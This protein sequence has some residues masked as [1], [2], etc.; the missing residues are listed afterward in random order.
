MMQLTEAD[1]RTLLDTR[2]KC[3]AYVR[4]VEAYEEELSLIHI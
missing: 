1:K 2:K 4:T 3:K